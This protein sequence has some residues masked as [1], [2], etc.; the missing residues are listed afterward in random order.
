MRG[1]PARDRM[2]RDVGAGLSLL[3]YITKMSLGGDWRSNSCPCC[4]LLTFVPCGRGE[5]QQL[6]VLDLDLPITYSS[7]QPTISEIFDE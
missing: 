2:R 5:P 4:T 1:M 7:I 3:I 6:P